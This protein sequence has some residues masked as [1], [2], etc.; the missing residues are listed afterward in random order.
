MQPENSKNSDIE[1]LEISWKKQELSCPD[2]DPKDNAC[3]DNL[4]PPEPPKVAPWV[5]SLMIF[6]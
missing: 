5:D 1:H 4:D 6:S 2:P 3:G